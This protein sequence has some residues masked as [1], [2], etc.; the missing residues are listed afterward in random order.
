MAKEMEGK[1]VGPM[2]VDLFLSTF[3]PRNADQELKLTPFDAE[4]MRKVGDKK[5][6]PEM[7]I[8]LVRCAI[9]MERPRAA[10]DDVKNRLT[11]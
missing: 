6:E 9:T 4:M 1:F 10:S 3:L 7:Y 11:L 5:L 2:D 8:P